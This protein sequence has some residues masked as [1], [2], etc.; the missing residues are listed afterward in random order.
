[1]VNYLPGVGSVFFLALLFLPIKKISK[2]F[3]KLIKNLSRSPF[4]AAISKSVGMKK[5]VKILKKS[6]LYLIVDIFT[7][8]EI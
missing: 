4:K 2:L 5:L 3:L 1:M 6:F 8:S 7:S